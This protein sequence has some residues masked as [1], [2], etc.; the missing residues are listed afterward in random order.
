MTTGSSVL[1]TAKELKNVGVGV[2]D[3]VVLLDRGQGGKEMLLNNGITLHTVIRI[4]KTGTKEYTRLDGFCFVL[5]Y[6]I[7]YFLF[8]YLS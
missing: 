7:N 4:F 8:N 2:T 5:I 3:A 6:L 1:E